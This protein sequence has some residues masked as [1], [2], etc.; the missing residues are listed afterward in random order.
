M[1]ERNGGVQDQECKR[2]EEIAS[3]AM[4]SGNTGVY[5]IVNNLALRSLR[6]RQ[7]ASARIEPRHAL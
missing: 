6:H 7:V 1:E 4:N 2:A 3:D 5:S